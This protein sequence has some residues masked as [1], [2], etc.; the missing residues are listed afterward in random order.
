MALKRHRR[1]GIAINSPSQSTTTGSSTASPSRTSTPNAVANWPAPSPRATGYPRAFALPK[2]PP[3]LSPFAATNL[4]QVASPAPIMAPAHAP[5]TSAGTTSADPL[6][7]TMEMLPVQPPF[8]RPHT[9]AAS[10]NSQRSDF[11]TATPTPTWARTIAHL[12]GE[13]PPKR[14]PSSQP[15]PTQIQP[16]AP[17]SASKPPHLRRKDLVP[18]IETSTSVATSPSVSEAVKVPFTPWANGSA[19]QHLSPTDFEPAET[20]KV[21]SMSCTRSL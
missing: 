21:S 8:Q 11:S 13:S 6:K 18:K 1:L 12:L 5:A 16:A 14:T 15:P 4:V 19:M 20:V 3:I 10:I 17:S 9:P 2:A 7:G